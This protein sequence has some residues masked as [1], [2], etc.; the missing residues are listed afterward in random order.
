V[1]TTLP[2]A[3]LPAATIQPTPTSGATATPA[4]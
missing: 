4:P 3:T 1:A 2:A